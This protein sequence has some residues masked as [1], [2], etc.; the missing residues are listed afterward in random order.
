MAYDSA[1]HIYEIAI[2]AME[3]VTLK[4]V[5][6]WISTR[7]KIDRP[8]E[9]IINNQIINNTDQIISIIDDFIDKQ[10]RS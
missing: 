3:S 4:L 5:A 9:L 6:D 7:W 2:I 1:E 8:A 10:D